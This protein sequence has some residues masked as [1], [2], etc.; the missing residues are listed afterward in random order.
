MENHDF[1]KYIILFGLSGVMLAMLVLF[2]SSV[3]YYFFTHNKGVLQYI[4]KTISIG[5]VTI[6]VAIILI[7]ALVHYVVWQKGISTAWRFI[8]PS[9][10]TTIVNDIANAESEDVIVHLVHGTFETN[11]SWTQPESE[12]CKSINSRN[13]NIGISRFK[14]DGKNS[15]SSRKQAA[16]QLGMHIDNSPAKYNYIIAHSHGAAIV[17]EMSYLRS[18]IAKKIQG[19]CLLS[20]PFIFRRRIKRTSGT[21][22]N[23]IDISGALAIQLLLAAF[24]VPL[25][26][27][28]VNYAAVIFFVSIFAEIIISK[29]YKKEFLQEVESG[30]HCEA[31][32]FRN[33]EI[34]HAIGDE[35]DSGLR[36]VSSLHEGCFAILSQLKKA[37]VSHKKLTHWSA[38]LSYLF[39]ISMSLLIW[40]FCPEEKSW[41]IVLLV[42]FVL[43]SISHI[44]Q[45]LKPSKDIPHVLLIAAIPVAIFSF[46]LAVAKAIAYGDL[47]LIFCPEVFIASSETPAGDHKVIK[48][49]P[50]NDGMLI[51]STHS[52][53]E[54][55]INVSEWLYCSE[56]KRVNGES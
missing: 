34:Y 36:F 56:N 27:Y 32:D 17:R 33:V 20:P 23:L 50:Q 30:E 19:V 7:V 12:M 35:A 47:R 39:Y 31:V 1:I 46:W 26:L 43:T 6:P 2:I 15:A 22:I 16:Y 44:W 28:N 10:K 21:L 41:I 55:I 9:T 29:K 49:A 51:H 24:L 37:Q 5:L 14:W 4:I 3:A 45:R 40:F 54:A 8:F 38:V 48:F 18:D 42:S 53:P 11:A 13:P 25:N 52:H